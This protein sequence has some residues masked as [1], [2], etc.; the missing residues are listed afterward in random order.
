M[1][2]KFEKIEK[3][4]IPATRI[5]NDGLSIIKHFEGLHR[6]GKDGLVYPY[7]DPVGIPT[8]GYGNTY[9]SNGKKVTM[10][11]KPI[12]QQQ[13]A[14]MLQH[15]VN[16]RVDVIVPY[17]RNRAFLQHELDA[18]ASLAY[19]IG[20]GAL[21]TSTLTRLWLTGEHKEEVAMQFDRWVNA[22]GKKLTGLVRRRAT[23]KHLFLHGELKFF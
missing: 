11:D 6:V 20:V 17:F 15:D 16:K 21:Q 13:A 12:T 8:I 2:K 1:E 14:E 18:I 5:G 9:Y 19:N 23:E 7:L 4:D 3:V 22:G 10:R